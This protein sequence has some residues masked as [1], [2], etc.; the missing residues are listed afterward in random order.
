[1]AG[2][3]KTT[4]KKTRPTSLSLDDGP[5]KQ[6]IVICLYSFINLYYS[7]KHKHIFPLEEYNLHFNYLQKHQII[8]KRM[9]GGMLWKRNI[10]YND[11]TLGQ[12]VQFNKFQMDSTAYITVVRQVQSYF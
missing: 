7:T 10:I 11:K 1:M 9:H 3:R 6:Q 2:E 8:R 4:A 5:T 12:C